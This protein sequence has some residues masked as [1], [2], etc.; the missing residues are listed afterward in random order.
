MTLNM[1]AVP[2]RS[3]S[4]LPEPHDN[5]QTARAERENISDLKWCKFTDGE[6]TLALLR[7][8][9]QPCRN[10]CTF[11]SARAAEVCFSSPPP[12]EC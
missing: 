8:T 9:A 3:F 4:I 11:N 7:V 1:I 6:T 12:L 2:D 10:R 5:R